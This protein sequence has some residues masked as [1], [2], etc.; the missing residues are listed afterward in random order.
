MERAAMS[1]WSKTKDV[2]VRFACEN[3]ADYGEQERGEILAEVR[4]RNLLSPAQL[5]RL[6]QEVAALAGQPAR[7]RDDGGVLT[8]LIFGLAILGPILFAIEFILSVIGFFHLGE[9][10][11]SEVVGLT[12]QG[13]FAALSRR[14]GVALRNKTPQ[15]VQ[16]AKRL[17]VYTMIANGLLLL[18]IVTTS[19]YRI[20]DGNYQISDCFKFRHPDPLYCVNICSAW[21][22]RQEGFRF[23]AFVLAASLAWF[24][25]LSV[26]KRVRERYPDWEAPMFNRRAAAGA[27]PASTV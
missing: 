26:S 8:L 3:I 27:A 6:E 21:L 4:S 10:P 17:M 7:K 14:A 2:G 12:I 22:V 16:R 20:I 25:Y 9:L 19:I 15:A 24:V 23:T 18:R 11:V 5:L 13:I 1:V